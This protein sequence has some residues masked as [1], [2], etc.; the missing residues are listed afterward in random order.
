MKI[1]S[2]ESITDVFDSWEK[3]R[4]QLRAVAKAARA[5]E[6][7]WKKYLQLTDEEIELQEALEDLDVG[8]RERGLPSPDEDR[9]VRDPGTPGE[10][11]AGGEAR[12]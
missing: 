11:E 6:S 9:G 7:T 12:S 4:E 10:Q 2:L 5:V 3:E 8:D 1:I